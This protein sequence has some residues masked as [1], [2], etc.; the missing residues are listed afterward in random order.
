[1]F[2]CAMVSVRAMPLPLTT[3]NLTPPN[4]FDVDVLALSA[5]VTHFCAAVGSTPSIGKVAINLGQP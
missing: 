2:L 1:V 4:I 3:L 5:V